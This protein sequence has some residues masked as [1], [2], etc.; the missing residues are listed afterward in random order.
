[1]KRSHLIIL[2]SIAILGVLLFFFYPRILDVFEEIPSSGNV[3]AVALSQ[4]LTHQ[5]RKGAHIFIGEVEAPTP[6][7]SVSAEA[8]VRESYPE[9][10]TINVAIKPPAPD[11]IC[12]QVITKKKFKVAFQASKEA[13]VEVRVDGASATWTKVESPDTVNLEAEPIE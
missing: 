9:Q 3:G 5:Y 6:C 10:V 4:P 11:V 7:H 12:A 13:I 2:L 8:V 1:M